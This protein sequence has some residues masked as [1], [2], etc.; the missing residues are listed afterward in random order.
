MTFLFLNQNYFYDLFRLMLDR[1]R[2]SPTTHLL[3]LTLPFGS[4]LGLNVRTIKEPRLGILSEVP[5]QTPK[6]MLDICAI[7]VFQFE[8]CFLSRH[9]SQVVVETSPVRVTRPRCCIAS[10]RRFVSRLFGPLPRPSP[11]I[12]RW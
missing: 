5:H 8:F 1:K 6:K 3:C 11:C 2:G 9:G 12:K 7:Y 4:S 10:Q